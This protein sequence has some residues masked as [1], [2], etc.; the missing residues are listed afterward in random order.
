M[1]DYEITASGASNPNYDITY[2]TGTQHITP[3]A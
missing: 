3:A 2:A 1:G